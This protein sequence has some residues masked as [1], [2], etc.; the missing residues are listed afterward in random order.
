MRVSC[1]RSNQGTSHIG[2]DAKPSQM[3]GPLSCQA[4]WGK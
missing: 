2:C 3:R 4:E 1:A